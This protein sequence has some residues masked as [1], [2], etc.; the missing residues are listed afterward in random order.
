MI[1]E[2]KQPE[3]ETMST[4]SVDLN[5]CYIHLSSLQKACISFHCQLLI[6]LCSGSVGTS[7]PQAAGAQYMGF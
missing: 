6:R 3:K 2:A 1:G 7:I 5:V 4:E